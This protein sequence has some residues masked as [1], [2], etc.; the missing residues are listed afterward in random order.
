MIIIKI[1][2][3]FL[4]RCRLLVTDNFIAFLPKLIKKKHKVLIELTQVA[5]IDKDAGKKR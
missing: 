5:S 3:S 4:F 1:I 2:I